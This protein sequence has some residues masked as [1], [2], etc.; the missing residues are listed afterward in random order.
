M[1]KIVTHFLVYG[2]RP[3]RFTRGVE[4]EPYEEP[5]HKKKFNLLCPTVQ[6]PTKIY[7]KLVSVCITA[8]N[9]A[10]LDVNWIR[11]PKGAITSAFARDRNEATRV[12][13][14]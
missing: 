5:I 3:H 7:D 1:K 10:E 13:I 11:T 9:K 14:V 6:K 8:K 2:K 4:I 12:V